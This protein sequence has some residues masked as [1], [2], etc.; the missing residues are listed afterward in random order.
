MAPVAPLGFQKRPISKS[1]SAGN[2]AHDGNEWRVGGTVLEENMVVTME[3]MVNVEGLGGFRHHDICRIT[4]DGIE[5]LNTFPRGVLLA[6]DDGS[7]E[8]LWLPT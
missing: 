7:L 6:G 3:P 1:S 2:S 5:N 4:A 8:E